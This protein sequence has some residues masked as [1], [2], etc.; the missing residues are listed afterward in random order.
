MVRYNELMKKVIV[1]DLDGTLAESKSSLDSEMSDLLGTLLQKKMVAIISGGGLP[2]FEKQVLGKLSCPPEL[3]KK[4]ILFPTKGGAMYTFKDDIWQ[5]VYSKS[6]S[7]KEKEQIINAVQIVSG[8]VDFLPEKHFGE[9]LEDRGAEFTFSALGQE[10]PHEE[11]E[12]WDNDHVKRKIL[13]EKLQKLLPDF[14]VAI[15]GST[16]IDITLKDINKAFAI[17][18]IFSLLGYTKDEVLFVGDALFPGGNDESVKITGIDT[19]SVKNVDE[20]KNFI[21]KIISSPEL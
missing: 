15:G 5:Q 19:F 9:R 17:N 20:T 21:R 4:L 18:Q 10:A 7:D 3:L 14:D 2:Q 8:E 16:S 1:F 11:K 12:K 6:F 13:E